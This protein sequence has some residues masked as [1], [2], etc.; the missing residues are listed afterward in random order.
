MMGMV[1]ISLMAFSLSIIASSSLMATDMI[2]RMNIFNEIAAKA[3]GMKECSDAINYLKNEENN[4]AFTAINSVTGVPDFY[5]DSIY[6]DLLKYSSS[7]LEN[8][9][10]TSPNSKKIILQKLENAYSMHPGGEYYDL[11]GFFY[12]DNNLK[13][14]LKYYKLG[15]SLDLLS[16]RGSDETFKI[17]KIYHLLGDDKNAFPYLWLS[18]RNKFNYIPTITKM[19]NEICT[20][21]PKICRKKPKQI[22]FISENNAVRL[23]QQGQKLKCYS[24]SAIPTIIDLSYDVEKPGPYFIFSK[25]STIANPDGGTVTNS[26]G[27]FAKDCLLESDSISDTDYL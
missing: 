8:N 5:I 14:A 6:H 13:K 18:A 3:K 15:Y 7:Y 17:G 25:S 2:Q 9:C 16:N 10:E 23:Q 12:S 24:T 27:A 20:K 11:A 22:Q 19:I 21:S 1:R 26:S 4:E